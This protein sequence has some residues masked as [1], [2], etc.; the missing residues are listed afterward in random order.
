MIVSVRFMTRSQNMINAVHRRN[1][2]GPS[3]PSST[4]SPDWVNSTLFLATGEN[5]YVRAHTNLHALRRT[6]GANGGDQG[7]TLLATAPLTAESWQLL[8][9]NSLRVYA[10]GDNITP[11]SRYASIR[12]MPIAFDVLTAAVP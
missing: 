1:F 8:A 4:I 11:V 12:P 6:I 3:N 9:S 7:V 5:L 10:G 2:S